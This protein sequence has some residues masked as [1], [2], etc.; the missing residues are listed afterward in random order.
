MHEGEMPEKVEFVSES[1]IGM[2]GGRMQFPIALIGSLLLAV[3][4]SSVNERVKVSSST[5]FTF[6]KTKV[7]VSEFIGNLEKTKESISLGF[8]Y[9]VEKM[10]RDLD[11]QNNQ[12]PTE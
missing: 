12:A 8:Q 7:Y 4:A 5:S 3:I 6:G 9:D 10:L 1:Y 11:A 2:L